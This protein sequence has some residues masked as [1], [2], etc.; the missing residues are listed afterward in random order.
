MHFTIKPVSYTCN[1]NCDYCF[2]LPK[3]KDMLDGKIMSYSTLESFI[4]KYIQA[5]DNRVLFTWQG[6]EPM[7][8]GIDFFKKALELQ[9]KYK[10]NKIIENALQTNGTLLNDKWC[11]FLKQNNFLV[12][13]SI[14]G[15]KELHDIYR[16]DKAN[17]G[18]FDEVLRAINLLKRYKIEFN[19]LC[20]INKANSGHALE[21]YQFLKD[22]GIRYIQFSPVVERYEENNNLAAIN[23]CEFKDFSVAALEYGKFM[24]TIFKYW[25]KHDIGNIVIREFENFISQIHSLGALSCVFDN[26]CM[27]NL[28]IESNGDVYQCDQFV[29]PK[30]KLFNINEIDALNA[31]EILSN[32]LNSF[33]GSLSI[34]CLNCDY[35]ILCNGGCPKHRV[36]ASKNFEYKSYFCQGYKELF[37]NITPYLN[38]MRALSE[39]QIPYI[40]VKSI[41]DVIEKNLKA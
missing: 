35:K 3:G 38:A 13:I 26:K 32:D 6:G 7:L 25:I 40:Q 14:D 19:A 36:V 18:S 17:R 31:N 39:S 5:S 10:G 9:N 15:P 23:Q 1:L 22:I 2:Y 33:K 4:K 30:Y 21:V 34:D 37:K 16:K 8:C 41:C 12:G 20:C 11:E 28:V 27:N 24:S 29:Y